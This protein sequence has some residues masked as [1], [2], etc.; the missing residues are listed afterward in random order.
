MIGSEAE[1]DWQQGDNGLTIKTPSESPDEMAIV[2]KI[3][4]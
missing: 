3:S 1:L 2:L 4:L